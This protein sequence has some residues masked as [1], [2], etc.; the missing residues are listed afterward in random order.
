[1][2]DIIDFL[3]KI[4]NKDNKIYN[5]F[6]KTFWIFFLVIAGYSYYVYKLYLKKDKTLFAIQLTILIICI[7][8]GFHFFFYF[9]FYETTIMDILHK[10]SPKL[11][12]NQ[13]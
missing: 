4:K 5:Y 3:I 7:L 8:F 9:N 10:L 6:M 2:G 13:D 12:N 1:M 11:K